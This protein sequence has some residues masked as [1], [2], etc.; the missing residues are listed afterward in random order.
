M[1]NPNPIRTSAIA[2]VMIESA[3]TDIAS[4]A[5]TAKTAAINVWL[6]FLANLPAN[7]SETTREIPKIKNSNKISVSVIPLSFRNAG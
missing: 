7:A 4:P 2:K 1:L 3:T 5:D 6:V